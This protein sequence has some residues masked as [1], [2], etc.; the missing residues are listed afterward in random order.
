MGYISIHLIDKV[1][2]VLLASLT[3][4][5]QILIPKLRYFIPSLPYSTSN[6]NPTVLTSEHELGF[7]EVIIVFAFELLKLYGYYSVDIYVI[8]QNKLKCRSRSGTNFN[9]LFFFWN[10]HKTSGTLAQ[11]SGERCGCKT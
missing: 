6:S 4:E 8:Y 1:I 9:S 2:R 7:R 3:A 5:F 10:R 11:K